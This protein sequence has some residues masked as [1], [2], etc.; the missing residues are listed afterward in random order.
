[1]ISEPVSTSSNSTGRFSE[2]FAESFC[3]IDCT[4]RC[5]ALTACSRIAPSS[6]TELLHNE[7]AG[8]AQVPIESRHCCVLTWFAAERA[9]QSDSS[10]SLR[11]SARPNQNPPNR[12]QLHS[13]LL[14]FRLVNQSTQAQLCNRMP[15]LLL[16]LPRQCQASRSASQSCWKI[17]TR[18]AILQIRRFAQFAQKPISL[19]HVL[20]SQRAFPE[21]VLL[22]D[23]ELAAGNNLLASI[24]QSDQCA[25]LACLSFKQ[26]NSCW[27]CLSDCDLRSVCADPMNSVARSML[28]LLLISNGKSKKIV[29]FL[30]WRAH[31]HCLNFSALGGFLF[32]CS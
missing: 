3:A 12:N 26:T 32:Q 21:F 11:S 23:S 14:Q 22:V 15:A 24:E 4:A 20:C 10:S 9:L 5:A 18:A 27:L 25:Q 13:L 6:M 7:E 29:S 28:S 8:K 31:S 16:L 17:G 1:M 30:A 19:P 2:S